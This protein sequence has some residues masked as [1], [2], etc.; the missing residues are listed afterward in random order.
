MD[1]KLQRRVQRYGWDAA[2]KVYEASWGDNLASAHDAM[3]GRAALRAG[4]SVLDVACGSGLLTFRAAKLVGDAGSVTATDIS[5]EM[6]RLVRDK[7][8]VKAFANVEARRMDAEALDL[9]DRNFDVALCGLGLMFAPDPD[10]AMKEMWRTLKGGGRA[11]AAVWGERRN[12]GWAEIFGIVDRFVQTD[13]CPL[14]FRL[15]TGQ[16]LLTTFED[17]GF[18]MTS[19]HRF[20]V[21]L[22]YANDQRALAATVDGGAVALAARRFDVATRQEVD[23]QFLRSIARFRQA[24]GAYA[25]PGE[26]VVVDGRKP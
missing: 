18:V 11:V 9:P 6:V 7:A 23:R 1:A 25:I 15:G 19:S 8:R 20:S 14:F 12:C 26:F 13:V 3:F 4:E 21:R 24:N 17:A 5:E 16:S 10:Q 22:T 2:A